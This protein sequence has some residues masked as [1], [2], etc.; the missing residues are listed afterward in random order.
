[1]MIPVPLLYCGL[2]L[3]GPYEKGT[4]EVLSWSHKRDSATAVRMCP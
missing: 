2:L 1:M 3:S 4:A